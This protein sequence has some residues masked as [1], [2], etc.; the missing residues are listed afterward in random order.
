MNLEKHQIIFIMRFRCCILWLAVLHQALPEK[1]LCQMPLLS[2]LLFM[3][4]P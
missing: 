2:H 4:E 3:Y 1:G